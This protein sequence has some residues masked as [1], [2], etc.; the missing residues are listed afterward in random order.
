VCIIIEEKIKAAEFKKIES[1]A[2]KVQDCNFSKVGQEKKSFPKTFA[3]ADA[4]AAKD[5][6]KSWVLF[7]ELLHDSLAAEEIHGV[8]WWQFKSMFLAKKSKSAKEA[9]L[10]PFVFGKCQS[11][12]SKWESG[13]IDAFLKKLVHMYHGAHRGELDFISELEALCL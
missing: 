13:E 5:R 8:L 4:L 7:Q 10:N 1:K 12:S 2:E 6:K 3:F 9:R 11:F